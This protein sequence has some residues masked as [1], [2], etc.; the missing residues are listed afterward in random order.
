MVAVGTDPNSAEGNGHVYFA[1]D[2]A[3][4]TSSG[5][6]LMA[7]CSIRAYVDLKEI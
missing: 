3:I 4:P 5:R 2:L 1:R 7:N 6:I